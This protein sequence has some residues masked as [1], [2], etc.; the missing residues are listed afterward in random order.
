MIKTPMKLT[1]VLAAAL[2]PTLAGA[3]GRTTQ[4]Q[5]R[6]RYRAEQAVCL[7]GQ[8]PQSLQTCLREAEAAY[9][10]ARKST[11]DDGDA[12]YAGHAIRRCDPLPDEQRRD[13]VAR[14]RG[15]GTVSGS[16]AAGGIFRELVTPVPV[17]A[18][19]TG[20]PD[21]PEAVDR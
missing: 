19:L 21:K 9:A 5:A 2:L 12:D 17:K 3:V 14:M 8:S 16:V 18:D 15:A 1:L 4:A 6:D 13:C 20:K 7:N 10:Q 11:L